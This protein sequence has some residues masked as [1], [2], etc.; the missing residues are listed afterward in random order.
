MQFVLKMFDIRE[1][2]DRYTIIM[3]I[4]LESLICR[5]NCKKFRGGI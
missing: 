5:Q 4:V 1:C 2:N 3:I